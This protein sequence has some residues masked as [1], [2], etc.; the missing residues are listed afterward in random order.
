MATVYGNTYTGDGY[1]EQ[2]YLD[3]SAKT[4]VKEEVVREMLPFFTER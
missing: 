4:H 1:G 2:V 3:Y